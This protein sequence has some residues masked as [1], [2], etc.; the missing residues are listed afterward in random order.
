MLL[1]VVVKSCEAV[2][3]VVVVLVV[4]SRKC[5]LL[6]SFLRIIPCVYV[7]T[8]LLCQKKLWLKLAISPR[9]CSTE[10]EG[11]TEIFA[12]AGRDREGLQPPEESPRS[13]LTV[14]CVFAS[15]YRGLEKIVCVCVWFSV[16]CAQ[17]PADPGDG[18]EVCT[19]KTKKYANLRLDK[20]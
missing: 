17:L 8:L 20:K 18:P 1:Q 19:Q 6:P 10:I 16:W 2:V 15:G 5:I 3:Y 11:A 9:G 13:W 12:R 7:C 4:A 14:L